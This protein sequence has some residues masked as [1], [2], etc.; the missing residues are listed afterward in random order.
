MWR[1]LITLVLILASAEALADEVRF[2]LI[3]GT[4]YSIRELALSPH[5]LATWSPNVLHPPPIK[6][7]ERREV[8]FPAYIVDCNVDLKV[9][10]QED[11]SQPIWQYLNLCNL[12]KVRLRYD[13]MSGV[14]TASY[15]E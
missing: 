12:R 10:F 13:R 14:A 7:G 2:M 3:N 11:D 15:E 1:R 8:A 9:A 6:P 5:D 4:N